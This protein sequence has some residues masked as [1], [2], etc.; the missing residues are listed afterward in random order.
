MGELTCKPTRLRGEGGNW[1]TRQKP[2]QSQHK[3]A[4]GTQTTPEVRV[5][6]CSL[7]LW[8]SS[9]TAAY[10]ANTHF[11]NWQ[12]KSWNAPLKCGYDGFLTV[13][14]CVTCDSRKQTPAEIS[15]ST[16]LPLEIRGSV[17]ESESILYHGSH[18]TIQKAAM[19]W[20][21]NVRERWSCAFI[22]SDYRHQ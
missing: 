5:E 10:G 21:D 8:G 3:H 17:S 4:Y 15:A 20:R 11:R 7:A 16:S 1:S 2:M 19:E 9:C 12:K 14:W 13:W 6:C 22:I 18:T